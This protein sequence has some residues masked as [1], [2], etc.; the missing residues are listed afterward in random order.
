MA[1]PQPVGRFFKNK[2]MVFP[3]PKYPKPKGALVLTRAIFWHLF[4]KHS[5]EDFIF[6]KD[7]SDIIY[8]VFRYFCKDP[9]FNEYKLITSEPS[10]NKGIYLW[11]DNGVGKTYLFEI[12]HK[13]GAELTK[14]GCYDLWFN[15]ISTGAFVLE[16]MESCKPNSPSNFNLKD[17]YRGTLQIDDLGFEGM[18]FNKEELLSILLFERNKIGSRSFVTTNKS[19][20]YIHKRYGNA[21]GDRLDQD[22]NIIRWKGKTFR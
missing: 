4:Q 9:N 11:G 16:Y 3:K 17:F 8:T 10:L 1:K 2:Q 7:N 21:I 6:N 5:G 20:A 18:A 13:M 15:Q 19:P 14:Y 22:F 12:I